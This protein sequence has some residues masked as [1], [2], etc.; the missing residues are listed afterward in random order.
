M[1]S[2]HCLYCHGYEEA[3]TPSAGVLAVDDLALALPHTNILAR[4]AL[5]F[6]STVTV[7]TN[8]AAEVAEA[9]QPLVEKRGIMVDARP[10][11]KLVKEPE[12]AKVMVV[13]EDGSSVTHGFLVHKP[14]NR[15]ELG[16]AEA[17]GLELAPSGTE[18]K[19]TM[20]FNETTCK[21]CFSA[22]DMATP[23]KVIATGTMLGQFAAVGAVMQLQA[24]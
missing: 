10:I 20:P 2:F 3:G 8:G 12:A 7:Y 11:A 6:A 23:G 18:L 4:N 15:L 16:Y 13:F 14:K 17:L 22:G 21:G 5:Q 9:V 1:R 24:D 19:V